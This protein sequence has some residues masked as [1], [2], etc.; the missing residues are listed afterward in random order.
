MACVRNFGSGGN[1]FLLGN[2][3]DGIVEG[4]DYS[5]MENNVYYIISVMR[6]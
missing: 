3:N 4:P 5:I 1:L 2:S 6:P